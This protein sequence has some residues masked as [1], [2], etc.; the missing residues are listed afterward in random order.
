MLFYSPVPQGNNAVQKHQVEAAYY[1]IYKYD[2]R[3]HFSWLRV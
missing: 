2:T 3:I 1:T